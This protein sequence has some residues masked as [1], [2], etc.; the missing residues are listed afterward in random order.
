MEKSVTPATELNNMSSSNTTRKRSSSEVQ[1]EF[2]Q[3]I[4]FVGPGASFVADRGQNKQSRGRG[5]NQNSRGGRN[6]QNGQER[7]NGRGRGRGATN[8]VKPIPSHLTR[9]ARLERRN[10]H[11]ML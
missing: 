7:G 3:E 4:P 6:S 9:Q 8:N 1:R 11:A 5:K 10:A 2:L